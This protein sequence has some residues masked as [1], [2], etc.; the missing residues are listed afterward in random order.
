MG[1]TMEHFLLPITHWCPKQSTFRIAFF[2]AP[3]TGG[4]RYFFPVL[5]YGLEEEGSV[6]VEFCLAYA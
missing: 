4:L 1:K 5:P 6:F 2:I 3:I